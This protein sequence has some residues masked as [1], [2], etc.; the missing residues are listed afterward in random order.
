MKAFL[1]YCKQ[2]K[3][4]ICIGLMLLY[5][6]PAVVN[7]IPFNDDFGRIDYAGGWDHDGRLLSTILMKFISLGSSILYLAPLTTF[8]SIL[9]ISISGFYFCYKLKVNSV[10]K[11]N[12]IAL[13]ALIPPFFLNRINYQFDFLPMTCA[14]SLA[15]FSA[16]YFVFNFNKAKIKSCTLLF[17]M[18]FSLMLFYQSDINAFFILFLFL[19]YIRLKNESIKNIFFIVLTGFFISCIALYVAHVLSSFYI[20]P[21][22]NSYKTMISLFDFKSLT[23][24]Y[25]RYFNYSFGMY[26]SIYGVIC[27]V[28]ALLSGIFLFLKSTRLQKILFP[29]LIILIL[30]FIC[31][32]LMF[33][34]P[35]SIGGR[36]MIAFSAIYLCVLYSIFLFTNIYTIILVCIGLFVHFA[37]A[38]CAFNVQKT[39]YELDMNIFTSYV[40]SINRIN[41]K[42]S[43]VDVIGNPP[44][45]KI[46]N[47]TSKAFP[48]TDIRH[49]IFFHRYTRLWTI[50]FF[51]SKFGLNIKSYLSK[52]NISKQELSDCNN[53]VE[54]NQLYNVLVKDQ[55]VIFDFDKSCPT[56]AKYIFDGLDSN[57]T[58]MINKALK[59]KLN[60]ISLTPYRVSLVN[61]LIFE[62]NQSLYD[63]A[64]KDDNVFYIHFHEKD[65]DG[66]I[67]GDRGLNQQVKIG[68]RYYLLTST[69]EV[70][71]DK[72]DTIRFGFYNS[73]TKQNSASF[74]I[75]LNQN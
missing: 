18:L 34:N 20:K 16:V 22:N 31:G 32:P 58:M 44:F 41:T 61:N 50:S 6:L 36:I 21:G 30:F 49:D 24:N 57:K 14:F 42:I 74:E 73:N 53:I 10:F 1:A 27:G 12:V 11:V 33:F 70:P 35:P 66:F 29:F 55:T 15:I 68:D 4:Y 17:I 38:Y 23:D 54:F 48:V 67:N 63:E 59:N 43:S 26:R 9:L 28:I 45:A 75:K 19:L 25:M 51:F 64:Q 65:K 71:F 52:T 8:I 56:Q 37:Q 72:I 40:A 39:Q 2:H 13:G 5:V 7:N 69:K 3:I 47:N 60:L 46:T 62:F